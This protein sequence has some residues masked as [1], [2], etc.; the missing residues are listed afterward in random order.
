VSSVPR[1][2]LVLVGGL[3][4]LTW[5][6]YTV[7]ARHTWAWF[8]RD[9]QSRSILAVSGARQSLADA[10]G[11][12]HADRL[13]RVL[14]DI[15]RDERVLG[16]R[17]CGADGAELASVGQHPHDVGDACDRA[18]APASEATGAFGF[19]D[20]RADDGPVHVTVV[21]VV[22]DGRVL[23][24]IA[25]AHDLSF[26]GRRVDAIRG[27]LLAAFGVL[28]VVA[29]VFTLL[30]TR[31]SWR[32]WNRE[33][34]SMLLGA[35]ARPEFAPLMRDVRD[36][37]RQ[38][39]DEV[40]E[41]VG[42][43]WDPAR[44][45]DALHRHLQGERVII[46]ANR[47]P[48]I[49]HFTPEGAV[50]VRH[51]A[52]GLVTALEP[53]MRACSGVWVAHGSGDAD[54]ETADAEGRLRVPPG[55]ESYT[56]RRV[57]LTPAQERGYYYGFSNEGLWPLCHVAHTRPVFRSADW[58]HYREVNEAFAEAVAAEAEQ[59][60]PVVLVQDYHFALL[61][62]LLR[63][64]L[65]RATVLTFWHIPWPNA[66]RVG[67]CPWK[68]ELLDGLLGSSILGFHTQLHCN[69]FLESVD[70]YLEARID[71]ESF[72]V[73]CE[74]RNTLVRPY[75]ISI[76]WPNHWASQ[77][78]PVG[79]CRRAVFNDLE[80]SP[81]VRL[82]VGVD[83]LDYTKGIEERLLAVERLFERHPDLIGGFVF[84]QLA[85][86]SRSAIEEYR[87]LDARVSAIAERVNTRFRR[88]RWCPIVLKRAHHEP[89]D[90]FR[91]YRAADL[92]YVSSL[93][94]GM[95][96]VAKEFVSAREDERGALVLS[97]FAGAARELTE[98][99]VVNPYDLDE[100]A[101]ALAAALRMPPDEQRDRIRAMRAYLS[102]FNVYR[103]AGRMLIDAS[104]VRQRERMAGRLS[105]WR[106]R[107]GI[108]R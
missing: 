80:L 14:G 69:N 68:A 34:R 9:L 75:P 32:S 21:P 58:E 48:Y 104:R 74:G 35:S 61:P 55:E 57:W 43:A 97:T 47:E 102:E 83:R 8:E 22:S 63:R 12:Q 105:S 42:A 100:A 30:V 4:L 36:L 29:S 101:D 54:R 13:A 15:A 103:W 19:V 5:L 50:E 82:G 46:V 52:S 70:R 76:E 84:V 73:H 95:N 25:M 88:G 45:K 51:P 11:Q 89:Q 40:R 44:L 17:A 24:T 86:P 39:S 96:L 98:A 26:V 65:P 67:I 87:S 108:D 1:F 10:W 78:A 62:R 56:L 77:V 7:A 71:R 49:H 37:V 20:S 53:V 23:G 93:H 59:D 31:L 107:F 60:D 81:T 106:S 72:A 38:L 94:D 92:C 66:E 16:L 79:D 6:A 91:Y 2:V 90:V 99:L 3:A 18:G 33:L 85:A 28:A 64:R 41:E 27:M